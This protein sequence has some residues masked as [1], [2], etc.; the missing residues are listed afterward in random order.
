MVLTLNSDLWPIQIMSK[1]KAKKRIKTHPEEAQI[2]QQI[3]DLYLSG[4]GAKNI[5]EIL[6]RDGQ[7]CRG[8]AWS[9]NRVIDIIGDEAYVGRYYF[10]VKNAI[11]CCKARYYSRLCN[12]R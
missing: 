9:K 7:F 3:Y 12:D 1:L 5:V 4:E 8:K 11:S 2:V 6:N 10:N